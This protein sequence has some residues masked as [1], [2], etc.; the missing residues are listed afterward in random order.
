MFGKNKKLNILLLCSLFCLFAS[1]VKVSATDD[2]YC[3]LACTRAI[4]KGKPMPS[5]SCFEHCYVMFT[6]GT[7]V[8]DSRGYFQDVGSAQERNIFEGTHQCNPVRRQA[9]LE[10]W[11][12]ITDVYDKCK[13][14]DYSLTSHNCCSVAYEAIK[15]IVG[16]N[17]MPLNIANANSSIGTKCFN[18]YGQ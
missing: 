18:K 9:S 4:D 14:E 3:I 6:K 16:A 2:D 11:S 7:R 13:R 8:L 5:V 17:E 1:E 12:K 10:E 15:A